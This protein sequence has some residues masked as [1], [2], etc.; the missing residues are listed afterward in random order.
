MIEGNRLTQEQVSGVIG[1]Q[2]HFPG[3]ERDAKLSFGR[4]GIAKD[5]D[6]FSKSE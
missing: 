6:H 3:R 5:T 2:Q 1:Q 4:T